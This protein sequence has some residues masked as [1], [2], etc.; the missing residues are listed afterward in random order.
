[1]A[2]AAATMVTVA[3]MTTTAAAVVATTLTLTTA[4]PVAMATVAGTDNNELKVA[5]EETVVA[6]AQR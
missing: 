2:V 3:M 6:E 4:M 5:P 1:M